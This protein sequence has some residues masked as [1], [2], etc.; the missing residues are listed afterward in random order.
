M[1]PDLLELIENRIQCI[2]DNAF[3]E[4]PLIS[5]P[6]RIRGGGSDKTFKLPAFKSTFPTVDAVADIF[7]SLQ[8]DWSYFNSHHVCI[9][10]NKQQAFLVFCVI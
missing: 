7:R 4:K 2:E 8:E 9:T 5:A 1:S 3:Y 10:Q 6:L